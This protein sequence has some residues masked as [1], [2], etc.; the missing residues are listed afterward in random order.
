[1]WQ[2]KYDFRAEGSNILLDP[3]QVCENKNK[4][5]KRLTGKLAEICNNDTSLMREIKRGIHLGFRECENQ[6]RNN[7]WNCTWTIKRSMRRILTRDTRETAFVH[8]ITAA[9][10][11]YAV[12]KACTMGDLL[13][14]SCQ[15]H[16]KKIMQN[17][18]NAPSLGLPGDSLAGGID[19]PGPG[20]GNRKGNRKVKN[21]KAGAY[22]AIPIA[23]YRSVNT[24][25]N[26]NSMAVSK[27]EVL[28]SLPNQKHLP[29]GQDGS[30]EWGGCDDNVNFGFR[31]SKDFLDARLRKKSDIR[32]LVKLHNNNAGRLAV[33]QFMRMECKCH[34][35]S[36]S[37]TMRTCWMKMPAFAEV[38]ARLKEHFDGATKV[39]AKNDGHSFM[40]D[41]PSIKLPTKRDLVYTEDSDD[42]CEANPKTGSLGTHGRECNITSNGIDGCNLMCCER[43]QIRKHVEVKRNCKC[44]FKWCCEVTCSTCIDVKEV[45]SCK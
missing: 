9:G 8:A 13:E 38:G 16:A 2:Q 3:A 10:I 34:G 31:K 33:K 22:N 27:R 28:K 35:L 36:G 30:W 7:M 11:T 40:P 39:I 26:Y 14:C 43:G 15:S 5:T 44:S 42:F 19:G 21:N 12:T 29:Q 17:V 32:T 45:Y 41:D 24:N 25:S 23:S 20:S 4:K 1:M 6:F 18:Q 37:C